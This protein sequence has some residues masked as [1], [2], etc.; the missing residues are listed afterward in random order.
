MSAGRTEEKG[1][2]FK[3][4]EDPEAKLGE[5]ETDPPKAIQMTITFTITEI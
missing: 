3:F 1:D 4:K 5:E 2:I